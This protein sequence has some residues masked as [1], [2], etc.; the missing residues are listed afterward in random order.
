MSGAKDALLLNQGLSE[1]YVPTLPERSVTWRLVLCATIGSIHAMQ[2]GWAI[3]IIN[4]PADV[5]SKDLGIDPKGWAWS[6]GIVASFCVAGFLGTS[7]AGGL[8]DSWGRRR[9][10]VALNLPFLLA[11]GAAVGAGLLKG[12]AGYA[13]L[14]L[15]RVLVGLA[16]GMGSVV[17]PMY[18]GEI[19]TESTRGAFGAL[20]QFQ[21]TVFILI[22]QLASMPGAMDSSALWGPL[23]GIS[24]VFAV[25]ALLAGPLLLESPKWLVKQGRQ[26]HA[27]SVLAQL[28]GITAAEADEDAKALEEPE[29]GGGDEE[30][31]GGSA[32]AGA[33]KDTK[34]LGQVLGDSYYRLPLLVLCVLMVTQQ[35]SGIN[36]IFYYSAGFFKVSDRILCTPTYCSPQH[37][38]HTRQQQHQPL[39]LGPLSPLSIPLPPPLPLPLNIHP[40]TPTLPPQHNAGCGRGCHSGHHSSGRREFTGH[41]HSHTLD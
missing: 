38:P 4:F 24:G 30:G 7:F 13:L 16:C 21:I 6:G 11:A 9:L 1:D 8:A 34:T 22:V 5:I 25:L 29:E 23:F 39:A 32:G 2:Y 35:F 33:G 15:S 10:I 20:F 17:T 40:P 18:L 3:G 37:H 36:A 27:R 12:T 19:A 14:V 41:G 26:D 28:R 31:G